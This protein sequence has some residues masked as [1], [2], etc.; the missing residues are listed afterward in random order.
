MSSCLARPGDERRK[1]LARALGTDDEAIVPGRIR[2]PRRV[3]GEERARL[4]HQALVAGDDA[5]AS[6]LLDIE[7]GVVEA[8]DV[9]R[10]VD[11][12]HLAVIARQVVGGA[13]DDDAGR[14]EAHLELA[15]VLLAAAIG[16]GDQGAHGY[17]AR[18][19]RLERLLQLRPIE[20]EDD[21]VDR[22]LGLLDRLQQRRH[23]VVWLDDELHV[24]I[25]PCSFF[26]DQS[27]AALPSGSSRRMASV[28][29]SRSTSSGKVTS[30][31]SSVFRRRAQLVFELEA[32]ED[33]LHPVAQVV[34]LL[35]VLDRQVELLHALF[36]RL[37]DP[38]RQHEKGRREGRQRIEPDAR[39]E[40]D[41]KRS[42]HHDRVLGI[43]DLGA[44]ADQVRGAD[45]AEGARQAG[46]DNE[47]D[48]GADH[49]EDDLC[50]HH[51]RHARRRALE[52]RAQS[53]RGAEQ[54]CQ[55]QPHERIANFVHRNRR[56]IGKVS[57]RYPLR[58]RPSAIFCF[59]RRM[60]R[61]VSS[62]A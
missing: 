35:A 53:E 41:G 23:A 43:V 49:R 29:M 16:V 20:A 54:G 48:D 45:D 56:E 51:C 2:L 47:H 38:E 34:R 32:V 39:G 6:A 28:T 36:E 8:E 10:V 24:A 44:V 46:A 42:Q 55:R 31:E 62:G 25:S 37:D 30:Y 50:L 14:E 61:A 19:R 26:L 9:E 3:G 52:L 5:E 58:A 11:H 40:P 18:H 21:D 13:R 33:P 4:L 59:R 7:P 22:A 15:Q 27:T 12:H 17:A 60:K 57:I 1:R